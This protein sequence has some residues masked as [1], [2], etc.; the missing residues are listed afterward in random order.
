M[1]LSEI[2]RYIKDVSDKL[3]KVLKTFNTKT[4]NTSFAK[5]WI[6]EKSK[7][8]Y[9]EE[10]ISETTQVKIDTFTNTLKKYRKKKTEELK[11]LIEAVPKK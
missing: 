1:E 8:E 2:S 11:K 9:K 10:P 5:K 7:G 3:Q 4:T 6:T